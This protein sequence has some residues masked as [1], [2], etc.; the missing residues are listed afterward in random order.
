MTKSTRNIA[1]GAQRRLLGAVLMA[2]AAVGPLALARPALAQSVDGAT[3]PKP[4]PQPDGT[5]ALG[6]VRVEAG[7]DEAGAPGAAGDTPYKT[8]APISSIDG[9]ELQTRFSGNPQTALRATPGVSTRQSSS[10][11]GIEVNIRGMSGYGRVNAMIDGVPQAFKNIAGHEASGGSL[12]YIQ[13]E[14][15]AGIDVTRGAVAGAHGSGTLTGA[16]NF[17][18][19]SLDDVLLEGQTVGGMVRLKLGDNGADVAGSISG[20]AR[21]DGL[22]GGDGRIDVFAGV[23]YT[24]TGDYKAGGGQPVQPGRQSS[25]S[26]QGGLLKVT[27]SPNQDHD[28][29]VGVRLYENQFV[30]SNYTWAIDNQTWTADYRFT[31]GGNWLNLA[32][33]AYY[34]DTHLQYVGTGGSYAG[35]ETRNKGYGLNATNRS[36]LTLGD[37]VDVRLAYGVSWGREDFQTLAMRGGNHPGKLDKTSL[38]SDAEFDFGR[39]SLIAG[40][41]YDAWK[42]KG[43]RPPYNAGA[44]DCPGP[45]GGPPCGDKWVGRDGGKWL[46]KV[47]VVFQATKDLELYATYA[48]T[49]RPPTTHEVFFSLAPF[50]N[51]VGSGVANNL[52]LDAETNKGWDLGA[53]FKRDGLFRDD[54]RL[55]LKVGYF[56]NSIDN[57]IVNDFVNVPGRGLTAMWVNRPGET[58]M[59]GLEIEGGYDAGVAY[60]NLAFAKTDTDQP[61]GDGAGA[62]NGEG[63]I[64]PDTTATLDVGARLFERRLILGAQARYTGEGQVAQFGVGWTPTEAYTLVDLYGSYAVNQRA[65]LFFSVE[66]VE[67]KV[68]GYA[69]SSFGAYSALTG[70]GRTFIAGLTARF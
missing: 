12:L 23:A 42:M 41:R 54:D 15:L 43:Y 29:S 50:G 31:P 68:Y 60:A 62:G 18:T 40:L 33:S 20:G 28:F 25:N 67:D 45:V 58:V 11:P 16:A 2:T 52:D 32:V 21:F 3:T 48:H 66:N 14:L 63:S 44:G 8:A 69:A 36:T 10:Q 56:R 26:P 49:F 64:L 53:N 24:E 35:R 57:F 46:P 6:P 27:V 55:R 38:F 19:L 4:A 22:W 17:R 1:G 37:D 70:R 51:G 65:E 5:I 30:N 13:P 47:G 59:Q 61:V 9:K 7:A 39:Y 34:N